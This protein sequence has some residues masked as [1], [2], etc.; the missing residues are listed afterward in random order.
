MRTLWVHST[1]FRLV[2][3]M[4]LA[5]MVPFQSLPAQD[6]PTGAPLVLSSTETEQAVPLAILL[7]DGKTAKCVSIRLHWNSQPYDGAE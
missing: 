4:V 6:K 5:V 1:R 2:L 7:S 3:T